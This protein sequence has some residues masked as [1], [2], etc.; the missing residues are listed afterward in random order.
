M[1]INPR[2][3]STTILVSTNGKTVTPKRDVAQEILRAV[4]ELKQ[5]SGFGSIEIVL[6]EGRV[7]QI[8]KREKFRFTQHATE[9]TFKEKSK[10]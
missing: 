4:E 10:N 1:S 2:P 3:A 5:G 6:H 8:E 7:T 9:S